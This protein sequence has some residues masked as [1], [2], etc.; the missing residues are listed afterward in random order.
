VLGRLIQEGRGKLKENQEESTP[1]DKTCR[2]EKPKYKIM[3]RNRPTIHACWA[4]KEPPQ[5]AGL[6]A[7]SPST[8]CRRLVA[9]PA[10]SAMRGTLG[11][12]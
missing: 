2:S 4:A 6:M 8:S 12:R 9:N 11:V 7:P 10:T 1:Q 3:A 5:I